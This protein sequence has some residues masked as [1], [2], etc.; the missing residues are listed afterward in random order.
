MKGALVAD[1]I[2]YFAS[3]QK[4]HSMVHQGA[5]HLR[6]RKIPYDNQAIIEVSV[7]L[8]WVTYVG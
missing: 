7:P 6:L 5:Y 2:G 4:P 3:P 8:Y 1:V